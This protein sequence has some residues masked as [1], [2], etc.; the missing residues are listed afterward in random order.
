MPAT[1]SVEAVLRNMA[2]TIK[3]QGKQGYRLGSSQSCYARVAQYM[4]KHPNV[5]G[6]I[7][8][9]GDKAHDVVQHAC[10]Y[11]DKG[12]A[13]VDTFQGKFNTQLKDYPGKPVEKNGKLFYRHYDDGRDNWVSYDGIRTLRTETFRR[14]YL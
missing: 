14:T 10:L 1:N 4:L 6:Y 2:L 8:L 7:L 11:D 9:F 3:S 13:L 5:N 12:N